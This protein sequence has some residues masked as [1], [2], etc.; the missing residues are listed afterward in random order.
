MRFLHEKDLLS[1]ILTQSKI[2]SSGIF[3]SDDNA[4]AILLNK[5]IEKHTEASLKLAARKSAVH[6]KETE[7]HIAVRFRYTLRASVI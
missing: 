6:N 2:D 1:C 3:P 7:N 4:T 5:P